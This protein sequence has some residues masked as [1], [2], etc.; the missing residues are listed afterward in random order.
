[1]QGKVQE[2]RHKRST[3]IQEEEGGDPQEDVAEVVDPET[4][5]RT[6]KITIMQKMLVVAEVEEIR[7][8]G[9]ALKDKVD[10]SKGITTILMV[11]GFV[12]K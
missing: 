4:I 5:T 3:L 2:S 1:M 6:S 7:E 10:G 8:Q 11:A 9:G 12:A